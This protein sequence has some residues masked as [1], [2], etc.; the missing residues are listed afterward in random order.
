MKKNNKITPEIHKEIVKIAKSL[1]LFYRT[2]ISGNTIYTTKTTIKKWNELSEDEL[3]QALK[4]KSIKEGKSISITNRKPVFVN[5][6][7]MLIEAFKKK[8][9]SGIDSYVNHCNN[10]K[11]TADENAK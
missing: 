10:L 9:I 3:K 2:D 11:R 4:N 6:E 7:V 5:H 1:P 8:G